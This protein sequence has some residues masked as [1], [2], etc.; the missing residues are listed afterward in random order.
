MAVGLG[1]LE[2]LR[3]HETDTAFLHFWMFIHWHVSIVFYLSEFF[4]C[5]ITT[6]TFI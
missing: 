4:H 1:L 3:V 6:C 2:L 5:K